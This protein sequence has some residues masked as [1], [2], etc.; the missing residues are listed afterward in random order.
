VCLAAVVNDWVE[1]I[2]RPMLA[3]VYPARN[4]ITFGRVDKSADVWWVDREL[5]RS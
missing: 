4:A 3:I 2:H 1:S 5:D